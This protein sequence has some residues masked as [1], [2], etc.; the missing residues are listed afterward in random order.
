[1]SEGLPSQEG[2]TAPRVL[3]A[4]GEPRRTAEGLRRLFGAELELAGMVDDVGQLVPAAR[5]LRV[6]AV[7]ADVTKPGRSGFEAARRLQ[8]LKP[9]PKVV[10]LTPD[11]APESVR[12]ALA[13]GVSGYVLK[14]LVLEELLAALREVLRG[15]T[16]ISP[17]LVD[18]QLASYRRDPAEAAGSRGL[19]PSQERVLALVTTGLSAKEI[20]ARLGVS[21]RTVEDHKYR[22]MKRLGVRNSTALLRYALRAGI[23]ADSD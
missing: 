11:A 19:T 12:Q 4:A 8:A 18:A 3:V 10:F 22:M 7:V 9:P 20:A 16:Y 6:D 2:R 1:M 17:R 5:E 23:T 13:A 15:G 14:H 21:R